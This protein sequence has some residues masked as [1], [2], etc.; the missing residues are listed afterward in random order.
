MMLHSKKIRPGALWRGFIPFLVSFLLMG[1]FRCLAESATQQTPPPQVEANVRKVLR[2]A[3]YDKMADDPDFLQGLN[4]MLLKHARPTSEPGAS[5]PPSAATPAA[6]S[7]AHSDE[8]YRF[9]RSSKAPSSASAGTAP[10][11]TAPAPPPPAPVAEP[12]PKPMPAKPAASPPLKT[13]APVAESESAPPPLK[14]AASKPAPPA[15]AVAPAPKPRASATGSGGKLTAREIMDKQKARHEATVEFERVKMVLV[16]SGGSKEE[17]LLVRYLKKSGDGMFKYL[18]RFEDPADIRGVVL[19]TWQ[20]N[21]RADDQWLYLPAQGDKLKR[22][23]GGNKKSAFMGTDFA[24]EDL[25][26]EKLDDH[27]YDL[28]REEEYQRTDKDPKQLCYVIE[29]RPINE[30]EAKSTGYSKRICYIQEDTLVTLKTDY[31]D[32]S[33]KL[34]K[35]GLS[36]KIETVRGDM[37]RAAQVLM[38][39]H[40]NNHKTVMGSLERDVSSPIPDEIFTERSVLNFK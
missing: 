32:K 1:G 30:E 35:T 13:T 18:L 28:L 39:H 5:A 8:A 4:Y 31:Y 24:Y 34:L 33:G 19:L 9:A 16:D 17:R 21:G 23:V 2:Q 22:I 14:P 10:V 27:Q 38:T 20:Q 29:A 15:E 11:E 36:Y 7:A 3:G 25:R 40:Q 26:S 37:M 6:A 12:P